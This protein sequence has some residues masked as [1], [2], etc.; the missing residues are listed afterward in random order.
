[1]P[2]RAPAWSQT[3]AF[4]ILETEEQ[5]AATCAALHG[6]AWPANTPKRLAITYLPVEE[7]QQGIEHGK[8]PSKAAAAAAAAAGRGGPARPGAAVG[9]RLGS[10]GLSVAKA[11]IAAA[12]G[13][14]A[15]A[16]AGVKRPRVSG[17]AGG[18][19]GE[20]RGE[21]SAARAAG[22]KRARRE[23]AD[24]EAVEEEGAQGGGEEMAGAE[25]EV[26]AP[27]AEAM[28]QEEPQEEEEEQPLT[29]ED[30]FRKTKAWPIIF[31]LPL[32]DEQVIHAEACSLGGL[33]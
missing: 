8:D 27:Q 3:H 21:G 25:E 2:R 28:E 18:S 13:S 23:G 31:W 33:R 1:M 17:E 20:E 30:L 7:A 16:A 15:A 4:V 10:G 9:A 24:G 5:G 11:A 19:P 29:L 26:E 22:S 12:A 32:T 14:T 6:L